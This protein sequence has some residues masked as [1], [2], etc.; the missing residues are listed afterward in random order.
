ME[1]TRNRVISNSLFIYAGRVVN[2]ACNFFIFVFLA[3]YL[4]ENAFGR[5]SIAIAYV[6]TFDI[7]ANF[8]LNQI[9]V[10]ELAGER[11][12]RSRLLGS[13]LFVK[14]IITLL[15][16]LA[17]LAVLP[18]MGYPAETMSIVW[19]IAINLLIS[20]KLSSTRT[21]FESIF[22]AQ[23]RM[24]FPILCNM[25][26]NLIF[27][28]LVLLCAHFFQI[29]LTGMAIIY[30]VC[31]IPGTLWLIRRF[32]K[33]NEVEWR[34]DW[35]LIKEL[36]REALPLAAYLFFS[37]LTTKI[38]VLMLSW[39]RAEAEVG[40][41]AAATRLVYPLSFLSTSLTISLFPLLSK[42]YE[43]NTDKFAEIAR[44][45]TRYVCI[46]A[47]LVSGVMAFAAGKIIRTLYV[48][49]YAACIPAFRVLLLSLGF[50]FLNFYFIDILISA[51]RQKM[52]TAVMA[53]SFLVNVL[54]NLWLIP[55]MGILGAGYAKLASA[56]VATFALLAALHF[57][58]K[59]RHLLDFPRLALL[60]ATLVMSL[61]LMQGLN[62]IFYLC[63]S[64]LIFMALLW[65]LGI[66]TCEE[67]EYFVNLLRN[68]PKWRR[69]WR[70]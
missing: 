31:N 64:F 9:L 39:M 10:R 70:N 53:L 63:F 29:G 3:N 19:I 4:G 50:S 28:A 61:W 18:L 46:I 44:R 40:Q 68:R 54:L 62:L 41:Y 59:I 51:H 49:S 37:I 65:V 21:V 43:H 7:I 15:A 26:D 34:P 48:P 30:T 8:G 52:V 56:G 38:D 58:L 57:Q 45:G 33:M 23:L 32:L 11:S 1:A 20:S 17:A 12:L 6:G 69:G 67:K 14:V 2:L 47:L 42:Y 55:Q 66:F 24:A 36:L 25:L 5:L 60:T 13:G 22:Q 16:V 35:P 27:A